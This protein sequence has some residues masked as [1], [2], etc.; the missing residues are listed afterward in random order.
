MKRDQLLEES[1]IK[2]LFENI[3]NLREKLTMG[4]Q[5]EFARDLPL[6]ELIVDRWE[7][8]ESL[9]FGEGS[10]IYDSS[11]VFMPV[12][13]GKHCWIGPFSIIDGSGGLSIGDFCT[14]SA[15]THIY[16]HDNVKNTL[17]GKEAEIERSEVHIGDCTYVGPN[18]II[19][20][21]VRI[22]SHAIVGAM[23]FVNAD[24]PDYTI[25]VGQPAR[26][27]GKVEI[28]DNKVEIVYGD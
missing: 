11:L 13:V 6:N 4:F 3:L 14:I 22:G 9:G 17:T 28:S 7:R 27:I 12:R 16:T 26:V 15:G 20:K 21:G 2:E 1:K 10:S 19:S 23:S 25:V 18:S 24:V 8:A 5:E